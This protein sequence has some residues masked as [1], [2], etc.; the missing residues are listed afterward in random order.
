MNKMKNDF[1]TFLYKMYMNQGWQYIY[2]IWYS[3]YLT[4]PVR[5]GCWQALYHSFYQ[6]G[7]IN[8]I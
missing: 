4:Q 3:Y 8:F 2:N 7:E 1:F 5:F 6:T